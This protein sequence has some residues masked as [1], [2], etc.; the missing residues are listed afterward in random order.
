MQMETTYVRN[1]E[2]FGLP[3]ANAPKVKIA[4]FF[5]MIQRGLLRRD[6]VTSGPRKDLVRLEKDASLFMNQDQMLM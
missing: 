6:F 1:T 5:M 2:D 3:E 4:S